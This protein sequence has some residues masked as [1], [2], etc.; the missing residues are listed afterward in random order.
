MAKIFGFFTIFI[1]WFFYFI[2]FNYGTGFSAEKGDWGTFGDFVGGVANPILTFITMLML[3]KS[4]NLQKEANDSL[5][6]QNSQMLVD[7]IRQ[8][9]MDDLRSFESS[10]YSLGEVSRQEFNNLKILGFDSVIYESSAAV[11]YIEKYLHSECA[12]KNAVNLSQDFIS[13]DDRS[14]MAIYSA[15]R[16][17]YVLFKLTQES[18]PD[19][20][21]ERY[22]EICTYTM[23]VKFIH[24]VSLS[25]V[26]SEWKIMKNFDGFNFFEKKGISEYV[27]SFILIKDN[28]K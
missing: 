28:V 11:A 25:Y 26:F 17:F 18:C 14:C 7:S 1:T 23:P 15:V 12:K 19:E 3:I 22:M 20:Y 8:K 2:N 16:S 4:I 10:F 27:D 24:L 6:R 5:I 9:K 13:L 21:K